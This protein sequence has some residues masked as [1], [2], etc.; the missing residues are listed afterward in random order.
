MKPLAAITAAL[1]LAACHPKPA[2]EAAASGSL[3]AAPCSR[4][5]PAADADGILSQIRAELDTDCLFGL[6]TQQ[7]AQAWGLQVFDF[8]NKTDQE[9]DSLF[10][11]MMAYDRAENALYIRRYPPSPDDFSYNHTDEIHLSATTRYAAA[12]KG[13]RLGG[14]PKRHGYPAGFPT[15]DAVSP[16]RDTE[17]VYD[18]AAASAALPGDYAPAAPGSSDYTAFI[19]QNTTRRADLPQLAVLANQYGTPERIVVYRRAL[20]AGYPF[21]CTDPAACTASAQATPADTAQRQPE[22]KSAA[23]STPL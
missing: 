16:D 19:W 2:A 23:G 7:L 12:H 21:Y 9:R 8:R 10:E 14:D 1:L 15:P 11:Q 5:H 20:S 6:D 3:A 4:L 22:N 13:Y 18:P 17:T